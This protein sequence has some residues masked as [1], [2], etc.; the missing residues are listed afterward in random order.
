MHSVHDDGVHFLG[1]LVVLDELID[2]SGDIVV[3]PDF[4]NWIVFA[5]SYIDVDGCNW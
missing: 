1:E 5:H 2:E 4:E 3:G